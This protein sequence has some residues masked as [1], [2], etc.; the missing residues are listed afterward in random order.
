MKK[1]VMLLFVS[2]LFCSV[3]QASMPA[4]AALERA[5]FSAKKT[6]AQTM[7]V[8]DQ[9]NPRVLWFLG[10]TYTLYKSQPEDS[11]VENLYLPDGD[12]S[13]DNAIMIRKM[14]GTTCAQE[15]GEIDE[16][17]IMTLDSRNPQDQMVSGEVEE[18]DLVKY[19]AVRFI[20]VGPDVFSIMVSFPRTTQTDEE[21]QQLRQ[22]IFQ[23][24]RHTPVSVM[25]Q[26]LVESVC[27]FGSDCRD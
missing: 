25:T 3:A 11:H 8:R 20:Q 14:T 13:A 12:L 7:I 19:V 10:Q 5:V 6:K 17:E 21:W 24:V 26:N 4:A 18:D 23:A 2:C 27:K 22:T 1:I 15:I 9:K 16:D